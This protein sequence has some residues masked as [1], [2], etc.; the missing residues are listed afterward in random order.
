MTEW[1]RGNTLERREVD[2]D[3]GGTMRLGAYEALLDPES[4]VAEIYGT[5]VDN[6]GT[7]V[8]QNVNSAFGTGSAV[9]GGNQTPL[10]P[11][12]GY[13]TMPNAATPAPAPQFYSPLPTVPVPLLSPDPDVSLDLQKAFSNVYDLCSYDLAVDYSKPP[14]VALPP[15]LVSWTE[16]CLQ[17]AGLRPAT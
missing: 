7:D 13:D 16:G 11:A 15:E 8:I 12:P 9:G 14:D 6:Y 4:R 3:L 17:A 10:G 5:I 1:V 2:G